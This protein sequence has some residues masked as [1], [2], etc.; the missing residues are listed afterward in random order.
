MKKILTSLLLAFSLLPFVASAASPFV[1]IPEDFEF[2]R[3]LENLKSRN[4]IKGFPDQTFAPE[5]GIS[6]AEFLKI[7]LVASGA[8]PKAPAEISFTDVG[9][10]DWFYAFVQD[11]KALGLIKGFDDNTFRPQQGVTRAEA[12]KMMYEAYGMKPEARDNTLPSDV[13]ADAW[14]VSYMFAAREKWIMTDFDDGSFLPQ[15]QL[16][17]GV[18][19]EILYRFDTVYRGKLNK[20][21]I[22]TEWDTFTSLTGHFSLKMPRSWSTIPESTRT[23]FWKEDPKLPKQDYAFTT[24]LSGKLIVRHPATIPE[25]T[26]PEYF[27][28]VRA[29][30]ESI[31]GKGHVQFFD[32]ALGAPAL[33]VVVKDRGIENWYIFLP[34]QKVM[35]LY[36]EVGQSSLTAKLRDTVQ[37]MARSIIYKPSAL[38]AAAEQEIAQLSDGIYKNILVEKTGKALVDGLK[39]TIILET[40]TIGVGTG[41]VDYYYSA[42]LNMTM[43]YERA[44]DTILAVR[45]GKTT[46]F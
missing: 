30:S 40:D 44:S 1:D 24:G 22:T 33:S 35:I 36:G 34:E 37:A 31:F 46:K 13:L 28:Q 27:A 4:V 10:D 2:I 12:L 17:R 5:K 9:K 42:K 7:V 43:K 19:A 45:A 29:F 3:A 32:I 38:D 14:F 16:T 20:F 6:R 21:D 15:A 11:G 25:K 8:K 41:P 18:A 39:D 26:A 23:V